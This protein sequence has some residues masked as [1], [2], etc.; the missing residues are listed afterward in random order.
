[1]ESV[2]K[3]TNMLFVILLLERLGQDSKVIKEISI[4]ENWEPKL[5]K[6]VLMS[7]L[8]SINAYLVAVED[9]MRCSDSFDI[10]FYIFN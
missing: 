8:S 9:N 3:Y 2:F 1:M 6:I 5:L 7:V 10:F 4:Y